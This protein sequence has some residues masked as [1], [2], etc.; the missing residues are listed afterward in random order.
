[1]RPKDKKNSQKFYNFL[2]NRWNIQQEPISSVEIFLVKNKRK[3]VA[4][5]GSLS[6]RTLFKRTAF[7]SV[8]GT[9]LAHD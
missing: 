7:D 9:F 5:A 8:D 2:E 3:K 1:M 6:G 4:E